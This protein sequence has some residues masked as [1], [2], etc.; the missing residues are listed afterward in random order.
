[1]KY[2]LSGRFKR[3]GLGY[4]SAVNVQFVF[5]LVGRYCICL[6]TFDIYMWSSLSCFFSCEL[7]MRIIFKTCGSICQPREITFREG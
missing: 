5:F 4:I 1:M 3:N 6:V 7:E 2:E